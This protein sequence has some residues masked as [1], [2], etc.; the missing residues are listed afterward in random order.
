M[1]ECLCIFVCDDCED[2]SSDAQAFFGLLV[3]SKGKHQIEHDIAE[4]F[5]RSTFLSVICYLGLDTLERL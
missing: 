2:V 1:Q 5:S 4:L 3:S